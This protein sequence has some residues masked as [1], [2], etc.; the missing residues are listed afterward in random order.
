M[1][2]AIPK[3]GLP[4]GI[5]IMKRIRSFKG[6]RNYLYKSSPNEVYFHNAP[7]YWVRAMD[8]APYFWNERKGEQIS[9]HVKTLY[10][11]NKLD[12]SVVTAILNS[13]LFYFWFI[14]H[15]NCRDLIMREIENFP[16]DI[17][18]MSLETKRKLTNFSKLLMIDLAKNAQRKECHYKTTGKV[19]YDEFYPK[20]SK[21]LIAQIDCVLSEYYGFTSEEL[22]FISNYDIKYRMGLI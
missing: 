6:L 2:G 3:I 22:D 16:I 11:E 18:E 13:S 14:I 20:H 15:S 4:I 12:A 21:C 7:Q 5:S 10:L 17:K 8:F 1:E 19:K 9:T